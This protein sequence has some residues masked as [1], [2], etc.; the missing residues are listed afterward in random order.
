M[1]H[2]VSANKRFCITGLDSLLSEHEGP[3]THM[4][5]LE[6]LIIPLSS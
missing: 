1:G 6:G 5:F 2:L 4:Q 3:G